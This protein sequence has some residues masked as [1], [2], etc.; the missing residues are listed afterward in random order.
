MLRSPFNG[1]DHSAWINGSYSIPDPPARSAFNGR[2][3]GS[4][5][6][7]NL[8]TDLDDPELSAQ[9]H[10][11][12]WIPDPPLHSAFNGGGGGPE[13]VITQAQI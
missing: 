12:H 11:S 8:C 10:G 4:G 6:G 9:I 13:L 2:G 5:I 1:S 7:D 3:G